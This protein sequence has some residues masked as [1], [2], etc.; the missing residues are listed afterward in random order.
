MRKTLKSHA[1][2]SVCICIHTIC[3]TC[4]LEEWLPRGTPSANK[5]LRAMGKGPIREQELTL[6]SSPYESKQS[7]AKHHEDSHHT[8]KKM[9]G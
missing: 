9:Y 7:Y 8:E 1:C 2:T 5:G 6:V 4:I 3:H